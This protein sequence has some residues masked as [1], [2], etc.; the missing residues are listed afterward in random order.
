MNSSA[1]KLSKTSEKLRSNSV[2]LVEEDRALAD[3]MTLSLKRLGYKVFAADKPSD[4]IARLEETR[5]W[6]VVLDLFLPGWNGLDLLD[7]MRK[8]GWLEETRV[9]IVSA[10]GFI[11][12]IQQ[13]LLLGAADF[14]V[15]PLDMELFIQK[16]KTIESMDTPNLKD[17]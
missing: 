3:L 1:R 13:A 9:L 5:P 17:V 4:A 2:L 8:A 14:L 6:L 16:I 11:E 15:K 12:V 7:I 10:M